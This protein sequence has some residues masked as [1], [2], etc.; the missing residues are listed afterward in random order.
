MKS[1]I[2]AIIMAIVCLLSGNLLAGEAILVASV[3]LNRVQNGVDYQRLLF[4]DANDE[5]K[6]ELLK[7]RTA[8]NEALHECVNENDDGKLT[9]LQTKIQSIN[10]KIEVLRN[11]MSNRST[12][13]RKGLMKFIKSQYSGKYA[14]VI[15]SDIVSNND[16]IIIWNSPKITDLTDE[17]IEALDRELP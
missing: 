1:G 4:L 16:Q 11:A 12:D 8:L 15:D 3:D 13:G 14:L 10:N 5:V 9:I 6:A 2:I 17:I 7:L